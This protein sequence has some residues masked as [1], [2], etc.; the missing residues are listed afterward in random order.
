MLKNSS[1]EKGKDSR[2]V[3]E[4]AGKS[5][6]ETCLC[7]ILLSLSLV[8]AGTGDLEVLRL[9]RYLRSRVGLTVSTVG[10]GSHL[11][12]HMALGFLFL[13]GGKVLLRDFEYRPRLSYCLLFPQAFRH[14][15]VLAAEPR[16]FLPVD[17]D[18]GKLRIAK[19]LLRFSDTRS[20]KDQ[21]Y[22]ARAP[23]MLPELSKLKE[24]VVE[25]NVDNPRYWPVKFT[26]GTE[27]WYVLETLL[28]T[29]NGI[30]LKLRE[31]R[32][33]YG[34]SPIS[35]DYKSSYYLTEDKTLHWTIKG[36]QKLFGIRKVNQCNYLSGLLIWQVKL[37]A[38]CS[39]FLQNLGIPPP[40]ANATSTSLMTDDGIDE[41]NNEKMDLDEIT[42]TVEPSSLFLKSLV[43][44]ERAL[45]LLKRIELVIDRWEEEVKD[46]IE[47]YLNSTKNSLRFLKE[48]KKKNLSVK[49]VISFGNSAIL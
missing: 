5:T 28:S 41:Q 11:A 49:S 39:L 13:G 31:G 6:V 14:L 29:G 17:V 15:Y 38:T 9:I 35:Y 20:Y 32:F 23:H 36:N 46:E 4:L 10:Y 27:S 12:I 44:P 2:S 22:V 3:A 16:L 37:I 24:I 42:E 34:E 19:I 21:K 1:S 7:S 48:L 45:A 47:S 25:G 43:N 40:S 18:S 26:K 8:M 33:P 30:P